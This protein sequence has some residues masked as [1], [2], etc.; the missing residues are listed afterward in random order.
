MLFSIYI[1]LYNCEKYIGTAIESVLK[2]AYTGFELVIINDGSTDRS[3]EIA[4]R[5]SKLDSRVK[6]VSQENKGLFHAR[7][8]AFES[9][10]GD[11]VI[12][13][14][15][16]DLLLNG[17]LEKISDAIDSN[18]DADMIYYSMIRFKDGEEQHVI[19]GTESENKTRESSSIDLEINEY[20]KSLLLSDSMN[21][22]C[23]KAIRRE[24]LKTNVD[25]LQSY[26]RVTN[27]EDCI[28]TLAASSCAKKIISIDNVLYAY[29]YNTSSMTNRIS[30]K[31]F[32]SWKFLML[33]RKKYIERYSMELI[34]P[35]FNLYCRKCLAKLIAY[36][37]YSV[38]NIDKP[39]YY[40]MLDDI[41][42][43][44]DCASLIADM[45]GLEVIYR[46][47]LIL[48][49]QRHYV[50]LLQLKNIVAR[51]RAIMAR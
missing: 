2:Q 46:I 45:S 17:A 26:P 48:L 37:P 23:Q 3:L 31:N 51:I 7:I 32:L 30:D 35:D 15:A 5:Y 29:R 12:S 28:H 36:H 20:Y 39:I 8:K 33:E 44:N 42:A 24:L 14:D 13:L 41:V 1:P 50:I 25:G 18:P 11:Y 4:E 38:R 22:M 10:S 40:K 34:L 43:D 16:D 27:G 6:I 9:V 47:P 19:E 21:S 49:R